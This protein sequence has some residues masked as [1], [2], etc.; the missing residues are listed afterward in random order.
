MGGTFNPIH[1]G[2]LLL[3]QRAYEQFDLEK[4]YI[5]PVNIPPHK[6]GERI[7]EDIHRC[8][9]VQLAIASN[10]NFELSLMEVNRKGLTFTCDT[11]KELS[12]QFPEKEWYFIVG[13]DS[14]AS[15]ERWKHPSEIFAMA[16]I[17]VGVR[18]DYDEGKLTTIIKHLEKTYE[19]KIKLLKMPNIDIS[20]TDIRERI[21]SGLS[22]KYLVPESVE[23]YLESHRLYTLN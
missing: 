7:A 20:S 10:P 22:C 12:Q 4:V 1:L 16:T 14:L 15:M 2:H 17:V 18:E 9:M 21:R 13:A 5:M 3:S 23:E 6:Q 8:A 19:A 11:L